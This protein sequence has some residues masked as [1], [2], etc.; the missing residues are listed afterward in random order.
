MFSG[1]FTALVTPMLPN[2]DLDIDSL[3]A[4]VVMQ[5]EAGIQGLVVNGTTGEAPTLTEGEQQKTLETVIETVNRKIPVIAGTGS[6]STQKTIE[7]TKKAMTL[8]AD[9]CLLITPYYNRPTQKGLYEH[10]KAV[11]DNVPIPLILYNAPGRTGCDLLPETVKRLSEIANIVAFKEC[12]LTAQRMETLVA[13]C[14]ESLDL[15]S[16]NDEDTLA[17]MLVGFKGVISV[18]S[19]VV[20]KLVIQLADAVLAGDI[21]KARA[22]NLRLMSLNHKL[23][24]E[25]NPIPCK[26]LM[27]DLGIIKSGIRLPLTRLSEK[28][29]DEVKSAFQL[30]GEKV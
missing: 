24:V 11:A 27:E 30:T 28:Y 5:L 2:G 9:A 25:P 22:L 7:N 17:A 13:T 10:Y 21:V 16:G 19:N 12:V 14:G 23:F 8:G 3:Q 18:A 1:A 15:L 29:H 26:W 20:P 6:Y 4:L